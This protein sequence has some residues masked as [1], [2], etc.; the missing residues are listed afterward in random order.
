MNV[1]KLYLSG[2][3]VIGEELEVPEERMNAIYP[4]ENDIYINALE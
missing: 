1:P 4:D 2:K 3:V